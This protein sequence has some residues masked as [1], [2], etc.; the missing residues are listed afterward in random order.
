[1]NV[2]Y[3]QSYLIKHRSVETSILT[4]STLFILT[5]TLML[6]FYFLKYRKSI[7]NKEIT[8][9]NPTIIS[10]QFIREYWE[11]VTLPAFKILLFLNISPNQLTSLSLIFGF[12]SGIFFSLGHISSA[13]WLL[14]ISGTLDTLDGRVARYKKINSRAGAFFDSVADRYSDYFILAGIITYFSIF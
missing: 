11:W 7:R 1:M 13:G 5:L 14:V 9:R 8:A 4:L 3:G 2:D 10:S 12:I 6:S